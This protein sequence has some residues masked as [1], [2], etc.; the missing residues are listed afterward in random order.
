MN[1][2]L[3]ILAEVRRGL[4]VESRHRGAI[5]AVEPDGRVIAE[6]G[7]GS[8]ITST[9][10]TIKP[11]QAIPFITSGAAD[12]YDV[13]E[14]ELAAACASHE[15]EPIHTETVTRMLERAGLDESALG[16]G[17]HAPYNQETARRLERDGLP[18]TQIHNNCSGK[19]A[20]MLMTAAHQGLAIQ[21]YTSPDH[22]IQQEIISVMARLGDLDRELPTAIDGCSAPTFGVPLR[23]IA[24]AFA[25]LVS[26]SSVSSDIRQASSRLGRAMINHPEMVGGT[27]RFD[28][29]LLR[30]SRGKLVCKV[31]AEAVYGIGVLPSNRF[32]RG[33]GIAIK[34]EDGSYRGLGPAVIETLA[35]LGV[36]EKGEQAELAVYHNPEIENRLS[37]KVGEVLPSFNLGLDE[38]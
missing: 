28:T 22:P 34:M 33:L 26:P 2:S 20:A 6:L 21:D 10:S 25:R 11:I 5:I 31:G 13:A 29:D 27:G 23:S 12:R 38:Q 30:A 9:R 17:A 32:P 36:L 3:P 8:L 1:E 37:T 24:K 18:F 14:R 16:C 7:D 19:H 15:G 4:I 35:Q